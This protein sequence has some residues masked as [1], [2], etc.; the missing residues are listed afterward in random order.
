VRWLFILLIATFTFTDVS[1]VGLSLVTGISVKNL[2]LYTIAFALLFRMALGGVGRT[3]FQDL[4]W[5]F[6]LLIGYAMASWLIAAL[7]VKY[8]GYHLFEHAITLKTWAI[9]PALMMFAAFYGLRDLN[10]AKFVLKVLLL[11]IGAANFLTLLDTAHII[12]LGMKI[13]DH[14]GEFGR[15][16]GA[17]GHANETG[18]LLVCMLPPMVAWF[19]GARAFERLV[20]LGAILCSAVVLLMTVSR[21][22]FVGLFVGGLWGMWICRRYIPLQRFVMFGF[23]ATIG[24]VLAVVVAGLVDPSIGGTIMTRLTGTSTSVDAGEVSSG[25]TAIWAGA[26]LRML[27]TPGS[28]LWGFGWDVYSTMP[29]RYAPHNI[30]LSLWF[31][32]GLPGL[33]AFMFIQGR[34]ILAAFRSIELAKQPEIRVQLIAFVFAFLML[35][36]AMFFAD[37]IT[38]WPYIWMYVG[39]ILKMIVLMQ[40]DTAEEFQPLRVAQVPSRAPPARPFNGALPRPV[41]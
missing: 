22:A 28:F 6:T 20:W 21:G 38:P 1:G 18:S 39:V 8:P 15:V 24:V 26:L 5:A 16:F 41:R 19:Y 2:I 27:Q 33:T 37:L 12:H 4:H 9:D 32:L 40:E 34:T 29:F 25:R 31:E 30:Y 7:I 23:V 17:F 36:V 10:D 35:A 3:Y 11:A 14:G 13:G